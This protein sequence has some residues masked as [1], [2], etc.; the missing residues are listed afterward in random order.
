MKCLE[1]LDPNLLDEAEPQYFCDC[2]RER[3]SRI[4]VSIGREEL[5]NL[6]QTGENIEVC[7]HF[8]DKK[9]V[10]TPD[11]VLALMEDQA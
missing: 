11:E 5:Q 1:G 8:C 10:F 3:T 2:S 9:Y 6:A 4:L 7:C